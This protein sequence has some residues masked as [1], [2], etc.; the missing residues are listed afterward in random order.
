MNRKKN[1]KLL[2]Y[3]LLFG[4]L[5][6]SALKILLIS[7]KENPISIDEQNNSEIV[8]IFAQ[9]WS[10]FSRDPREAKIW[11]YKIKR[12]GYENVNLKNSQ[13]K[14]WF[15][16]KKQNRVI[17]HLV[18]E[19]FDEIPDAYLTEYRGPIKFRIK[20]LRFKVVKLKNF[21]YLEKG[22]YLI[23]EKQPIPWAWYSTI[24]KKIYMP[25]K[26]IIF[27]VC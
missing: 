12:D 19:K 13:I 26:I 5:I 10:F 18:K 3:Y 17:S 2:S 27:K 25:S 1:I 20:G 8:N 23:E 15:G 21:K 9:S 6:I 16:I 11:I 14:Y 24:K 22:N 4:F 7:I